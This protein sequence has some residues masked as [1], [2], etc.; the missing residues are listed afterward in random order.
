MHEP[1]ARHATWLQSAGPP[2]GASASSFPTRPPTLHAGARGLEALLP[3]LALQRLLLLVH[4][5]RQPEPRRPLLLLLLLLRGSP[6]PVGRVGCGGCSPG[7]RPLPSSPPSFTPICGAGRA[8]KQPLP[9]PGMKHVSGG[10]TC[11]H[12]SALSVGGGRPNRSARCFSFSLVAAASAVAGGTGRPKRSALLLAFSASVR[13]ASWAAA[14][15]ASAAPGSSAA[16][17][18]A[19]AGAEVAGSAGA[20]SLSSAT[21]CA[22]R[23]GVLLQCIDRFKGGRGSR[24][25]QPD[26]PPLTRSCAGDVSVGGW[27]SAPS[28]R[29]KAAPF[30]PSCASASMASARRCT[31]SSLTPLV[32][33]LRRA[34]SSRSSDTLSFLRSVT[35]AMAVWSPFNTRCIIMQL[36]M[37]LR[38]A[39]LDPDR[40]A[41]EP[42]SAQAHICPA[43]DAAAMGGGGPLVAV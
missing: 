43:T 31:R 12:T 23:G 38:V 11:P 15:G 7:L 9:C 36:G 18:G 40:F 34:S 42:R 22:S 26:A 24:T 21:S 28:P 37:A 39:A 3:Q 14:G 27:A 19:S 20:G 17:A 41:G 2:S 32:S 25:A 6:R 10:G 1:V 16:C 35:D 13:G 8:S 4:R 29:A 30:P 33:R 5:C